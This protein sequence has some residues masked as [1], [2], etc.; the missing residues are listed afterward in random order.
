MAAVRSF[1]AAAT[2][3]LL[4]PSIAAA[5]AVS[6]MSN[7]RATVLT[8]RRSES[9]RS[10]SPMGLAFRYCKLGRRA[11]VTDRASAALIEDVMGLLRNRNDLRLGKSLRTS[12]DDHDV[13]PALVSCSVV[14]AGKY[15][16]SS[17]SLLT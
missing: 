1:F 6:A 5:T 14:R 8:Y 3:F 15:M 13:M 16:Q 4:L 7:S 10:L 12:M 11:I 9:T 2:S 17:G